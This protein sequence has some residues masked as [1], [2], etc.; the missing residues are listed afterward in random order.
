MVFEGSN[1]K[2]RR[3]AGC[4]LALPLCGENRVSFT[5]QF[6]SFMSPTV[7]LQSVLIYP[8]IPFPIARGSDCHI[9]LLINWLVA[10]CA[11]DKAVSVYDL[12]AGESFVT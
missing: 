8:A 7:Y 4:Y 1:G 3:L 11:A 6:Q 5:F 12:F 10:I 2:G 9:C